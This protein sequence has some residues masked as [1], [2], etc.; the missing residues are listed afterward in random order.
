MAASPVA[1]PGVLIGGAPPSVG[2]A[3]GPSESPPGAPGVP[4]PMTSGMH[5][6]FATLSSSSSTLPTWM[7]LPLARGSVLNLRRVV[8]WVEFLVRVQPTPAELRQ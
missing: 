7:R 5:V 2:P 1:L 6:G 3:V 4:T 8:G